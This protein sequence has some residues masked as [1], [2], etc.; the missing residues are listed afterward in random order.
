MSFTEVFGGDNIDP[1]YLSYAAYTTAV[2]LQMTWAFEANTDANVMAAKMDVATT[3]ASIEIAMPDASVVSPGRDVLIKNT[4][5]NTFAV[6]D[7]DGNTLGSIASGQSW[8]F[9]II[10]NATAAGSWESVQF[11]AGTSSA[12]A[13][14]LAGA[15]LAA[16]LTRLNQDLNI[17]PQ[18]GNYA[19]GVGDLATV[20]LGT[21]GSVVYTPTSAATLTNGWFVW[22][23]NGGSGTITWTPP[24]GQTIDGASTKVLQPDESAI[25]FSDGANFW[26]AA[27]GRALQSTV[28]AV[29][30]PV[31]G[32]P[33]PMT[34]TANQVAAQIQDYTGTLATDL[35]VNYG[36]GVGFWF[37]RN[38]TSGAFTL[39]LRVNGSDTGVAI[40]QGSYSIIRSNGSTLSIAFTATSGT[41]TSVATTPDLTGGPITSTGTLGLSDTGVTPGTYGGGLNVPT[42]DVTAKGRITAASNVTLGSAAALTAGAAPG[43]VPVLNSIGL[44]P[45]QNGGVPPGVPLP[46]IGLTA[47]AGYVFGNSLTIGNAASGATGRANAD[48]QTLFELLWNSWAN[49]QAP[50][51]GGRGGNATADFNANKVIQLPDLRGAVIAGLDNNGGASAA[52]RLT[53]PQIAG[54]TPGAFGG[55]QSNTG[56]ISVSVSG[57]ASVAGTTSGTLSLSGTSGAAFGG[58]PVFA[59]GAGGPATNYDHIHDILGTAS[60]TL[61]VSGTATLSAVPGTIAVGAVGTVQPTVVMSYIV[62]L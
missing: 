61:S 3:A 50:V 18:P 24:G 48:T 62:K 37:V 44:V 21:G 9:Y 46:Y 5:A 23:I 6:V 38:A 60:G 43:N 1:S 14:S 16:V 26:S 47:P 32:E 41:V 7:F 52:G 29:T 12:S 39:T 33:D 45:T 10:S 42:F 56:T 11:G 20:L 54:T 58:T 22:V 25:F 17:N 55:S 27:Y 36:T 8:Y 4:G 30:I 19:P 34:L 40:A 51:S 2:D 49:A 28:S 53:A 13:A 57:T 31:T 35:T 15:G 59:D